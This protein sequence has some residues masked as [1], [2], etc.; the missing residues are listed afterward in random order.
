MLAAVA[1]LPHGPGVYRFRD[2]RGRVLYLGRAVDLRRRVASYW[3]DLRDRRHLRSMVARIDRVEA[4]VCD[5]E[6][7][8]SWLERNLLRAG[9]PPWN[10]SVGV[11]VPV[12]V[13]LDARPRSPGLAVVHPPVPSTAGVEVFGPYLGGARARLAVAGLQRA[14]PLAYT[15]DGLSGGQVDLAR[16]L[17]MDGLDRARVVD[18]VRR[19]LNRDAEAVDQVRADLSSRRDS[20]ARVLAFER[21]AQVQ[22]E[23]EA[24]DWLIAEQKVATDGGP[25]HDVAGWAEG[26]LVVFGV[27]DGLVCS[28]TQRRCSEHAALPQ[29]AATHPEWEPF[30]RRNARLAAAL[31]C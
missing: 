21:A 6:H 10:R 31:A 28:W 14:L 29:V 12:Y 26:M 7:E 11:E 25:D 1:S 20:A 5:S 19:V 24:L 17:G 8:A 3:G 9:R 13:R 15:A 4:V 2:A 16:S 18:T 22:A 23:V 27:R 30:A